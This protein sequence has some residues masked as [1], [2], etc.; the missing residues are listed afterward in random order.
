MMMIIII[1]YA[2]IINTMRILKS[3]DT[4]SNTLNIIHYN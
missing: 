2:Y 4:Q 1:I 3:V